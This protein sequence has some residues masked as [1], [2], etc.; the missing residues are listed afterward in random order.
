MSGHGGTWTC[1]WEMWFHSGCVEKRGTSSGGWY[2]SV[3]HK[4]VSSVDVVS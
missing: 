4:S 3:V 1:G 2:L